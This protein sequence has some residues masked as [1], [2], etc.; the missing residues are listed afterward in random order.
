MYHRGQ[1][2]YRILLNV[3]LLR[4]ALVC[5]PWHFFEASPWLYESLFKGRKSN[6]N[7]LLWLAA[8]ALPFGFLR[9]FFKSS[10]VGSRQTHVP[11]LLALTLPSMAL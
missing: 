9:N 7:V 4:S 10:G 6:Q 1:K 5:H 11:V 3:L 8:A 2:V